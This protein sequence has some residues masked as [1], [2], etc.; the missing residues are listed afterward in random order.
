MENQAKSPSASRSFIEK[1]DAL[2]A[3]PVR[4]R[5]MELTRT[6]YETAICKSIVGGHICFYDTKHSPCRVVASP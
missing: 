1:L 5:N 4:F 3:C 6:D 2:V